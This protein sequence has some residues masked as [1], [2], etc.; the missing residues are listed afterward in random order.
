MNV[1]QLCSRDLISVPASAT[2][3]EVA[4]LMHDQ[5][6]GSVVVI[7]SPLDRPVAVGVI[8]DRDVV[9]AQ[10]Q[11][12]ADLSRLRAEDV[13]TPNPLV[14]SEDSQPE[15]AVRKMRARAVRRAP[16]VDAHGTLIGL[17]STDDLVAHIG[18][19]LGNIARVVALQP[20]REAERAPAQGSEWACP[21]SHC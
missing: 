11:R 5:H 10:L 2:L 16:V 8:T 15:D 1:G 19:Q 4:R 17:V 12:T 14:L 3:S 21:P 20:M 6:I 7:K 18:R 9:R 13:M